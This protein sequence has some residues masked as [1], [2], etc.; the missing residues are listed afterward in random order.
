MSYTLIDL[1][2]KLELTLYFV[3]IIQD[4][5]IPCVDTLHDSKYNKK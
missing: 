4:T 3:I 5:A 1:V 2:D